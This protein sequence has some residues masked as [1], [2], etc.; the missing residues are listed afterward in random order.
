MEL[1]TTTKA[2]SA[3]TRKLAGSEFVTVDTE[4]IRETTYWPE[5]CLIQMAVPGYE[6]MVDALARGIDLEPFFDLMAD[7]NVTKV[8]HA[9]RQDIEIVFHRGNLIPHPVFDTQIAAMVCGFGESVSY[10][11]LVSEITGKKIDKTS[12][13]TDWRQRPLS[14]KQLAYALADVTHLIEVYKHL[15]DELERENRSHWLQGE[16]EVLTA[17]STYDIRPEDVWLRLKSRLRKP[18][19]FAVMRAVAAWREHEAKRR[20]LPRRRVLKDE[21]INEIAQQAPATPAALAK[22]RTTP[23]GWEKS[24]AAAE[25]LKAVKGALALPPDQMPKAPKRRS[26]P[27]GAGAAAELL[28]VL[29]R[30]SSEKSGVAAKVLATS[31]DIEEIAANG[32]D[33][34]VAALNGWRREVFGDAAIRLVR[35]EIALRYDDGKVEIVD[36]LSG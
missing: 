3:A 8:F 28:K 25:V 27:N 6:V 29:L 24:A 31:D 18:S 32:E 15:K 11:Q 30:M 22:L 35:G 14:E 34:K 2:L 10:E 26:A 21:A 13:F 20:N 19:E 9:G 4:F 5:L 12:R 36:G 23:R 7:E 17:R 1:I 33:A 16:M